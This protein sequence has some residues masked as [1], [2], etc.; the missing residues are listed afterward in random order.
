[1]SD[2]NQFDQRFEQQRF[3]RPRRGP[4]PRQRIDPDD[5]ARAFE[6]EDDRDRRREQRRATQSLQRAARSSLDAVAPMAA[7]P[8]AICVA[9]MEAS[10]RAWRECSDASRE[11][12][13]AQQEVMFSGLQS[14]RREGERQ[15]R[16]S[17]RASQEQQRPPRQYR[18]DDEEDVGR[19]D[20]RFRPPMQ[21][22]G[23]VGREFYD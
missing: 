10:L 13:R 23:G 11:V 7:L 8:T 4:P 3:E 15:Q 22:Q 16:Q 17:R 6:D 14:V 21:P 5:D 1:M 18:E 12:L 2:Y 9:A 20:R 19:E